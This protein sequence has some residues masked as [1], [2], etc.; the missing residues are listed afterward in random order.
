MGMLEEPKFDN[1]EYFPL[2]CNNSFT[3]LSVFLTNN[4][5]ICVSYHNKYLNIMHNF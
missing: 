2:T 3:L 1:Q 5:A 4:R